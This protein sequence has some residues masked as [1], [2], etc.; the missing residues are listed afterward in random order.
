MHTDEDKTLAATYLQHVVNYLFAF[1]SAEFQESVWIRGDHPQRYVNDYDEAVEEFSWFSRWLLE[2]DLWRCTPL[3]AGQV[4]HL[5]RF[6]D[7]LM[8]FDDSLPKAPSDSR[9]IV[10]DLR[11]PA[12]VAQAKGVLA[13]VLEVSGEIRPQ[14]IM[15]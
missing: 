7:E 4:E 5:R 1:S 3:G 2:G 9:V 10:A 6:Y 8:R 11:W 15:I 13:S 14:V 12:I